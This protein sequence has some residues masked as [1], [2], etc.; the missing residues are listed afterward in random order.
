MQE[1]KSS[2]V[3]KSFPSTF[4]YLIACIN[5]PSIFS[6]KMQGLQDSKIKRENIIGVC[7]YSCYAKLN[8]LTISL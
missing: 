7:A 1:D 8:I 4:K 6:S 2:N 3:N 5:P